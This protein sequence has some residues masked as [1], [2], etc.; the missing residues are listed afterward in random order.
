MEFLIFFVLFLCICVEL[1]DFVIY[2]SV[3]FKVEWGFGVDV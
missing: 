1:N 2:I 3:I